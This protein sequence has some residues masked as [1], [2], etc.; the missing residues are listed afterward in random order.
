MCN[1]S[2]TSGKSAET[3]VVNRPN[4]TTAEF[5]SKVAAD[6]EVTKSGGGTI[7]VKRK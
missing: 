1:C 4:G 7:T 3:Y 6:I 5:D 2:R